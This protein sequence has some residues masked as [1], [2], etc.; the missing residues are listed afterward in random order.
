MGKTTLAIH[1]LKNGDEQHPAYLNWDFAEDRESILNAQ[2]PTVERLI[3][4]DEVH[5]YRHWRN[6]VKGFYDKLKK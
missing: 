6:L 2:F 1:L 4:L 5:K 3:I